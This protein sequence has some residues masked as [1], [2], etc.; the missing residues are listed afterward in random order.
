MSTKKIAVYSKEALGER[1]YWVAKLSSERQTSNIILDYERPDTY[2]GEKGLIEIAL[3]RDTAEKLGAL[4]GN[5][6]FLIYAAMLAALKVCIHQYTG[7]THIVVGSPARKKSEV[8][9]ERP[10]AV[11]LIDEVDG[12][13]SYKKLL[14]NVRETLLQSYAKQS[15]P[16][17]ALL[18]DM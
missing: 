16:L 14:L 12:R 15:Y 9:S 7:N 6:A 1:D 4:S 11:A 18:R 5:S 17:A 2:T 13:M 10:N 3:P 8:L